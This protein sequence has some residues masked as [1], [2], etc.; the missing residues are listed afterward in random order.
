MNLEHVKQ[1]LRKGAGLRTHSGKVQPGDVFVALAGARVDGACFIDDAVARGAGVVIH[2]PG[3]A[4]NPCA[5]VAFL[6]VDSPARTL[7]ELARVRFGTEYRMPRIVGVTGTNGK[8]TTAYLLRH[9]M[10]GNNRHG[11]LLLAGREHS[12]D[13]DHAGLPEPA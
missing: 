1:E 5:G 2:A 9:L 8:T 11:H 4:V 13:P 6:A 10:A 3:V 7:G 12:I